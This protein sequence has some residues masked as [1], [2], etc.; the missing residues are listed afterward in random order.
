MWDEWKKSKGC[1]V[2]VFFGDDVQSDW[3]QHTHRDRD[4]SDAGVRCFV[5]VECVE[6]VDEQ[7]GLFG[8]E[9]GVVGV[10]DGRGSTHTHTQREQWDVPSKQA[11]KQSD[12]LC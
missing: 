5:C 7:Q 12:A 11:S 3:H 10:V 9:A 4:T 1:V 8:S 2:V 6:C